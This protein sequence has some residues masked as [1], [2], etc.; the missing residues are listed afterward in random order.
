MKLVFPLA[1]ALLLPVALH[2]QCPDETDARPSAAHQCSAHRQAAFRTMANAKT[3]VASPDEDRYDVKYVKLDLAMTNTSTTLSGLATTRAVVVASTMPTYVFELD[4]LLTVDSVKINGALRTFTTSGVV[5]T[6][7]LAAALA[8]GSVF[9]AEVWYRGTP[10]GQGGFFTN[11][12]SN[13]S[14]PTWQTQVT[15]SLSQPYNANDWWPCKQ[16]LQDKIDS[17]DVWVRVANSNL[18]A[19]SNGVLRAVTTLP[20]GVT[21][22]EWAHRYP[23]DYYLI[24]VAV[25]P[26]VDYSFNVSLPGVATPLLYQNFVY[27]NPGTLPFWK[28]RIDSVAGMIQHFSALFGSYPFSKEK[29]GHCMAPLGGGMEH[30]TMT[31]QGT[32]DVLLSAHELGHQW[33]GDWVTCATWKDIWLNEGFA[34]YSEYLYRQQFQSAAA[35]AAH[36]QDVHNS[37]MF[38]GGTIDATGS[39]YVPDTTSESRLFS[40]RLTYDKGSAVVHT[41]R[42][43]VGSDSVFFPALRAYG[44]QYAFG[45]ANTEGFKASMEASTGLDLDTFFAQ[46]VYGEGFPRFGARWNQTGADVV[47]EVFNSNVNTASPNTFFATPVD[48]RFTS[49]AGDTVVRLYQGAAVQRFEFS[50]GK[51]VTGLSF[52]P[53]NWLMNTEGSI[54][55]DFS[56][57]SVREA[58]AGA[59]FK[60]SPNPSSTAWRVGGL[61]TGASARLTDLAGRTLWTGAVPAGEFSIPVQNLPAGIYLLDVSSAA[62]RQAVRLLRQ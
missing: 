45:N 54:A 39:V 27:S 52:D 4:P 43:A 50:W 3:A 10:G 40:S 28:S 18:K 2:A 49:A 7:S 5:R 61:P 21:R 53:S 31:T 13:A 20:G 51:T 46:W 24:S 48:V 58:A 56:L 25:A 41:L 32:F 37:V 35:A 1:A 42:Y 44:Q 17:C 34:S 47:I 55:R 26:Y 30:Q 36:M 22:Y 15:W 11:G 38:P 23:I 14:S 19:G 59:G 33:W 16:S 60:V 12:L 6:V 29:Y 57:L 9:I 8:Q 62:G